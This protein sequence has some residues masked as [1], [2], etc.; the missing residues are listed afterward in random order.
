[1]DHLFKW[2]FTAVLLVSRKQSITEPWDSVSRAP[3][4]TRLQV[5]DALLLIKLN[6]SRLPPPLLSEYKLI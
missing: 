5:N 4:P 2:P 6:K 1:M 3:I